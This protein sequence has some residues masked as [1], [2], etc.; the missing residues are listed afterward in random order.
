MESI[1][2]SITVG[3]SDP[4]L[5]IDIP[6]DKDGNSAKSDVFVGPIPFFKGPVAEDKGPTVF[7]EVNVNTEA[8]TV[9]DSNCS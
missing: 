8:A 3:C 2:V 4:N 7:S 1:A 5:V 9:L 6:P